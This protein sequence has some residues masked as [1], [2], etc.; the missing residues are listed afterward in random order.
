[1]TDSLKL[2][3][4]ISGS[5]NIPLVAS[6]SISVDAHFSHENSVTNSKSVTETVEFPGQNVNVE[7]FSNVIISYRMYTFQQIYEFA[8]DFRLD[9]STSMVY[10][11]LG[12]CFS[13]KSGA[14]SS[15]SLKEFANKY[16]ERGQEYGKNKAQLAYTN[17][18]TLIFKG[19]PA[20]LKRQ[21][22]ALKVDISRAIPI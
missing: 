9:E 1:M 4:G 8:I 18:G 7:K 2:S 17:E 16:F 19:F 5:I 3:A 6:L 15:L 20:N 13:T 11:S 14:K 21:S 12:R 22:Y 10:S